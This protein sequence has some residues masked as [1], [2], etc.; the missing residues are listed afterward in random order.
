MY[1]N[2]VQKRV[3]TVQDF[4]CFGKCSGTVAL[5]ILSAM[6]HETVLLPTAVLST[7]TGGFTGYTVRDLT[8]DIAPISHHFESE[9]IVFD[10]IYTGYLCKG[11]QVSLVRELV[12]AHKSEG[13]L[14]VADPAMADAG[15]Y[16][17]GFDDEHA[18][19]MLTLCQASD[20]ITPNVTEAAFLLGEEYPEGGIYSLEY[21]RGLIERLRAVGCRSVILTS[22]SAEGKYG[23]LG[24]DHTEKRFFDYFHERVGCSIHGS[25]DTYTS[26]LVG[27]L[28]SGDSLETAACYAAD[29]VRAAVLATEPH[30]AGHPYGLLFETQLSKLC[31]PC[32]D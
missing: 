1:K 14:F 18:A 16:Y 6:G 24:Y 15:K 9:G 4:S 7:H 11:R 19:D 20:V 10:C 25:G 5:P 26:V 22:V 32:V 13:C 21:A 12:K 30:L 2:P 8:D 3:L 23:L 27:R 29:F 17:W 31:P 28:L